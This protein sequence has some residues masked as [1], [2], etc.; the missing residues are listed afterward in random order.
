MKT[1]KR[2]TTPRPAKP[3]EPTAAEL[4]N[5]RRADI[6]RLLDVLAMELE[7][8]D[9]GFKADPKNWGFPGSLGKVREDLI[10]TVGFMSNMDPEQV[11]EFLAEQA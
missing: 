3:A 7:R 10:N 8:H 11:E 5:A 1:T 4:Y 6:A 2:T 9:E